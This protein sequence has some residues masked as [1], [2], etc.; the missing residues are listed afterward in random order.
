MGENA[1]H[2]VAPRVED[3]LRALIR[4]TSAVAAA[5][6]LEEVLEIV[7]EVSC[8]MLRAASVSIS[9]W[10]RHAER[11]H[12]LINVGTLGPGEE[13][14]PAA[15]M[16]PLADFTYIA[17]MLERGSSYVVDLH[18]P[19]VPDGERAVLD[20]L[21][22]SSCLGVP[23]VYEGQAWGLLELYA[24][25]VSRPFSLADAPFVEALAAQVAVAIGRAE[26]FST[27][28]AF[29]YEDQLTGLANRRALEERLETAVGDASLCGSPVALLF[30]DLDGLKELNDG[31]G[32]D[33]GDAALVRVA[34][35]LTAAA[36]AYDGA[37]VSRI[38]GD[39]FCVLLDG[40]GAAAARELALDAARRLADGP[41][42]LTMSSG[43]AEL[44]HRGERPADLFRAADAAQYVAK[45]SGRGRVYVAQPGTLATAEAAEAGRRRL[46]DAGRRG[47]HGLA[48]R[49]L[50]L[51][52][53]EL[54][55]APVHDRIEAVVVAFADAFDAG[56]WTISRRDPGSDRVRTVFEGGRR[57]H[58]VSGVP[59]L[60]FSGPGDEYALG[61][62]PATA[63]VLRSG[64]SFVQWIGDPDGD[65]A[66]LA[67]LE[68]AGHQGMLA[69]AV[70][71]DGTAWLA[72]LN[73]DAATGP[74]ED[75]VAEL[76]LLMAEA[77]R[78][79]S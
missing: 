69:A 13:R 70:V 66:E 10:E 20:Q 23:I 11:L 40:G 3:E 42:P 32:H 51:L 73:Y 33:A 79:G 24:D 17:T 7:A 27:V 76:R 65:P 60:R 15:E 37:F 6:R 53:H 78:S 22:K 67:L 14:W 9:R 26:L 12:T 30:C 57:A 49:A 74:M 28:A 8:A 35:A 48:A 56:G 63:E 36:A 71:H 54:A 43:A 5:H 31:S 47:T 75:A 4:V 25:A 38:G 2:P 29:A 39:E 19:D 55:D 77:A 45:R 68:R 72:E 50:A 41:A 1:L 44:Q 34:R 21:G 59:S 61:E 58:R 64:G 16:W 52:E 18:D 62:Y 46:R